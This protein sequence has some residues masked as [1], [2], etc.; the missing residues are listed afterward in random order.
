MI[1]FCFRVVWGHLL[2]LLRCLERQATP[3][4]NNFVFVSEIPRKIIKKQ[5]TK[6]ERSIRREREKKQKERENQKKDKGKGNR[7]QRDQEK[8]KEKEKEMG[9]EKKWVNWWVSNHFSFHKDCAFCPPQVSLSFSLPTS[10]P[11]S[12]IFFIIRR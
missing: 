8:E 9:M 6:R 10:P 3:T 4:N 7:K 12:H 11:F 2:F 5:E 1:Y